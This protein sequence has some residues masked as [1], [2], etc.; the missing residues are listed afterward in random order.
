MFRSIAS[1]L[2]R[3]H[4]TNSTWKQ[5]LSLEDDI[6]T[7]ETSRS[8]KSGDVRRF[9]GP[10]SEAFQFLFWDFRNTIFVFR[11][12]P[13]VLSHDPAALW[14]VGWGLHPRVCKKNHH[15]GNIRN[16]GRKGQLG[17]V[18]LVQ[19]QKCCQSAGYIIC[20]QE[21]YELRPQAGKES[22]D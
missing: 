7:A 19:D 20:L 12:Q 22:Q 21:K 2:W 8:L 1:F 13:V 10:E 3:A 6:N 15:N 11:E 16:M 4:W 17:L 5:D 18:C 9:I 14:P